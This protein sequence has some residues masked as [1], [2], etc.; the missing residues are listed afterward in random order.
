MSDSLSSVVRSY[1]HGI[2][3]PSHTQQRL[4]SYD[5]EGAYLLRESCVKAGIFVHSSVKDS[6]VIHLAVPNKNWEFARQTFEEAYEVVNDIVNSY[7]GFL[8]PVSVPSTSAPILEGIWSFLKVFLFSM[9]FHTELMYFEWND[10]KNDPS[11]FLYS[12]TDDLRALID[13][14]SLI[15]WFSI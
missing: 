6:S 9:N 1:F 4:Q 2:L 5:R 14:N 3:T 10:T 12:C 7:D 8:H 11:L 15:F 13:W